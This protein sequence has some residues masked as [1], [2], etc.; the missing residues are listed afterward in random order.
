MLR[1]FLQYHLIYLVK[2]SL[3][4]SS[5]PVDISRYEESTYKGSD[6]QKWQPLG[7]GEF[8]RNIIVS[9]DEMQFLFTN[10]KEKENLE[11]VFITNSSQF[12]FQD[13]TAS[14]TFRVERALDEAIIRFGWKVPD[15]D[16]RGTPIGVILGDYQ[17]EVIGGNPVYDLPEGTTSRYFTTLS[18][19]VDKDYYLW[20]KDQKDI[21]FGAD[22]SQAA[23]RESEVIAHFKTNR[24]F[25]IP[26]SGNTG[27]PYTLNVA[28]KESSTA[29]TGH[30]EGAEDSDL[31]SFSFDMSRPNLSLVFGVEGSALDESANMVSIL[32]VRTTGCRRK[33][34]ANQLCSKPDSLLQYCQRKRKKRPKLKQ[35]SRLQPNLQ[36]RVQQQVLRLYK[37]KKPT[38]AKMYLNQLRRRVLFRKLAARCRDPA[39]REKKRVQRR[40]PPPPL[41]FRFRRPCSLQQA[42]SPRQRQ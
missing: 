16:W 40:H 25:D 7:K 18:Y 41:L 27:K 17:Q 26:S 38:R 15:S 1:F 10:D 30:S 13:L 32:S 21:T 11:E 20:P 29:I 4:Q 36:R 19:D 37:R 24:G 8:D 2:S 34:A 42:R 12:L 14:V 39:P 23:A 33:F 31:I 6:L 3:A 9:G 28:L 5:C 35:I 22:V